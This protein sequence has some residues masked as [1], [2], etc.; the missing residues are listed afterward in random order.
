LALRWNRF[1]ELV[2]ELGNRLVQLQR[3]W[4]EDVER[5]LRNRT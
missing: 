1:S 2:H 3:A 5:E 4:L